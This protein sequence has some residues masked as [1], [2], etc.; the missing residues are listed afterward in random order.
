MVSIDTIGGQ[1]GELPTEKKIVGTSPF[2]RLTAFGRSTAVESYTHQRCHLRLVQ[3]NPLSSMRI[4][5][6]MHKKPLTTF[7]P[8]L[9][10]NWQLNVNK[11]NIIKYNCGGRAGP[12]KYF[13]YEFNSK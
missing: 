10:Q 3:I 5:V 8:K 7:M 9:C 11:R 1:N 2:D 12:E 4:V 6:S 13:E